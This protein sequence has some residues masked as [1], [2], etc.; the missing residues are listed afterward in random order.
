MEADIKKY[1]GNNQNQTGKGGRAAS[2]V[3][4]NSM[5]KGEDNN[6]LTDRIQKLN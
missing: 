3:S 5:G 4:N 2:Q 1:I 6:E